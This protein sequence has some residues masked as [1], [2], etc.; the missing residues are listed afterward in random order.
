MTSF[1]STSPKCLN[2]SP[3]L[4]VWGWEMDHKVVFG[5]CKARMLLNKPS[6]CFKL[7][8]DDSILHSRVG[9]EGTFSSSFLSGAG[10]PQGNCTA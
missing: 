8:L 10:E 3:E 2:A 9:A 4:L 5:S 6:N 1:H 7:Q